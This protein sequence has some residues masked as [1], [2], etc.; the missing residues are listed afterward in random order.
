[1]K[2]MKTIFA[3][4]L[5]ASA[6]FTATFANAQ[7]CTPSA[8]LP[9]ESGFDPDYENL[10]CVV[11]G[12]AYNEVIYFKNF[13]EAALT[14]LRVDSING[15]PVGLNWQMSVPAANDP[16]TLGS[17]ERGCIGVSGTTNDTAG[18]YKLRIKACVKATVV[19]NEIC[20]DVDGL[21]AT[22]IDLGLLPDTT[23]FEYFIRVIEPGGVCTG[24]NSVNEIANVK[25]LDVSP[26]PFS[27]TAKISFTT[28]TAAKYTARLVDV[29]GKEVYN[30]TLNATSG[31]NEF[32]L[33]RN[34]M[35]TG[36]YFFTLTDGKSV[37][38]KRVV[39]E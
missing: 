6:V 14:Y 19:P 3:T 39:I 27:N 23:T 30:E 29:L 31:S 28:A 32:S 15:Q 13:E 24:V 8:T 9:V 18:I 1:M 2:T 7:V 34:N 22:F 25:G 26:N 36:V 35:T 38:T 16:R 21:I 5:V 20:D 33:N 10:P 17:G 37:S 11:R 4:V 12:Q